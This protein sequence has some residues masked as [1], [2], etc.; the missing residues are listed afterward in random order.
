ME[1]GRSGSL[2][3]TNTLEHSPKLKPQYLSRVFAPVLSSVE[4]VKA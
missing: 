3:G 2:L 4:V 1:V